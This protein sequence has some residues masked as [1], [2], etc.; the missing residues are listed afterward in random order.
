MKIVLATPLY[1][2]DIA[3]PAPY[4]KEL[5]RRLS[6]K[7]TV[8]IVTYA[9]IPEKIPGVSIVAINKHRS[10][11]IRLMNYTVAL[12]RTSRSAEVIYAQNG[13][14]VELP[15]SVVKFFTRVPLIIRVGDK[16]S[17]ARAERQPL[18][19]IIE[20]IAERHASHIVHDSPLSKPEW[21]P[22]KEISPEAQTAYETSW[23][24]HVRK[25][26]DLFAHV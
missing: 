1:P 16:T 10:L 19:H 12:W 4:V 23:E 21:L 9:Y 24:D 25:L 11:P 17:H 6:E 14:S 5:A 13:A 22:F 26:E 7:H 15:V 3:E 18:F 2:P 8:T 20:R